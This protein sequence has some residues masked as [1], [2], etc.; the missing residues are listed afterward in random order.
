MPL[1]FV[2]VMYGVTSIS[3]DLLVSDVDYIES[4]GPV[5]IVRNAETLTDNS[6]HGYSCSVMVVDEGQ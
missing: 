5:K 1:K 3:G 4:L 6:E 2:K